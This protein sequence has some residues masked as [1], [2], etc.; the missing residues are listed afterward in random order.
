M[1]FLPRDTWSLKSL[2]L[3]TSVRDV[4]GKYLKAIESVTEMQLS[5]SSE[6]LELYM[7][8]FNYCVQLSNKGNTFNLHFVINIEH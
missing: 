2:I 1:S 4:L 7:C 8:S 6:I 3:V 5:E